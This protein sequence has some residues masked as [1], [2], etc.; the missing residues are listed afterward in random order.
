MKHAQKVVLS[1]DIGGTFTDVVIEIG[2]RRLSVK[3]L[4]THAAPEA[5][6][7]E[8]VERLLALSGT[9][10]GEVDLF[11]HGTTL[12]TNAILERKGARTALITTQ[13]FRDSLEIGYENRFDQYDIFIEKPHPLVPRDLRFTVPER[14][15]VD[16]GV[17][18]PLDRDALARTCA[19]LGRRRKRRHRLPAQLRQPRA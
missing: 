8:G 12:A 13:G 5:G 7:M 9:E 4:T 18:L 11:V 2:E 19:E 16:G 1:A 17:L 14:V 15:A 3:V 6:V 10:P